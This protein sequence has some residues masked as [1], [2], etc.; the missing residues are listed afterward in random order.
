MTTFTDAAAS[1][2]IAPYRIRYVGEPGYTM[3]VRRQDRTRATVVRATIAV[4]FAVAVALAGV[5]AVRALTAGAAA[6]PIDMKPVPGEYRLGPGNQVPPGVVVPL[7]K[8]PGA[9]PVEWRPSLV[10]AP[11]EFRLGPG[12][13]APP[14]V[15]IPLEEDRGLSDPA[16]WRPSLVPVR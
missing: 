7:A 14:G 16:E 4:L 5:M 13:Q 2:P 3:P 9:A 15:Q 8:N 6:A 10:P 1:P 11:G 12:N